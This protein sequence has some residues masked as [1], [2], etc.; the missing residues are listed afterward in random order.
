M[1]LSRAHT[2]LKA[3]YPLIQSTHIQ[4]QTHSRVNII[5][6]NVTATR[7]GFDLPPSNRNRNLTYNLIRITT[8]IE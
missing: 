6:Q 7:E 8:K 2:S 4:N 3:Q 1:A 5:P